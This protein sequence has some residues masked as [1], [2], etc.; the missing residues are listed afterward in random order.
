MSRET[1][2]MPVDANISV[3]ETIFIERTFSFGPENIMYSSDRSARIRAVRL[4]LDYVQPAEFRNAP[5]A[6]RISSAVSRRYA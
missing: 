6:A 5:I 1:R 4:R 3:R 2:Q